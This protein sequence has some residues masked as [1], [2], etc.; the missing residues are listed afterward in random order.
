MLNDNIYFKTRKPTI[1]TVQKLFAVKTLRLCQKINLHWEIL[2]IVKQCDNLPR[3][4]SDLYEVHVYLIR[5][6]YKFK[7]LLKFIKLNDVDT[8]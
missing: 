5:L 4:L 1:W 6:N 2:T 8:N 3:S 7:D